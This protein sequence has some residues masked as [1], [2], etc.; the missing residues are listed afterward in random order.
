[1][2]HTLAW[3]SY[4]LEVTNI[5]DSVGKS[6]FSQTT[7]IALLFKDWPLTTCFW[8]RISTVILYYQVLHETFN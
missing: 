4:I 5:K 2:F 6:I 3:V 8:A 1:M 7:E